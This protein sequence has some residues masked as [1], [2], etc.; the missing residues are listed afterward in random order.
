[1]SSARGSPSLARLRV[2]EKQDSLVTRSKVWPCDPAWPMRC[3]Q[4]V[5]GGASKLKL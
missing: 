4:E 2:L 3:E 1:M 5:V